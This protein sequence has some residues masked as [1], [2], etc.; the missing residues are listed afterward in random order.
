MI[1]CV[2]FMCYKLRWMPGLVTWRKMVH[3]LLRRIFFLFIWEEATVPNASSLL[4]DFLFLWKKVKNNGQDKSPRSHTHTWE[5]WW[6]S[7]VRRG[8]T[9]APPFHHKESPC[10]ANVSAQVTNYSEAQLVGFFCSFHERLKLHSPG[11]CTVRC[12]WGGPSSHPSLSDMRECFCCSITMASGWTSW[13]EWAKWT[14]QFYLWQDNKVLHRGR[15]NRREKFLHFKSRNFLG[16][17]ENKL[18]FIK[19]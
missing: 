3:Y 5:V 11:W 12:S 19:A 17:R 8:A 9:W 10:S 6:N 14:F 15:E 13:T 16:C 1:F 18:N 7:M 2:C 4:H